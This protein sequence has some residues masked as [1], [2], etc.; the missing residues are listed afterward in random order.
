[1]NKFLYV[2]GA[3][4][5]FTSCSVNSSNSTNFSIELGNEFPIKLGEKFTFEESTIGIE[6]QDVDDYRCNAIDIMCVWAG[7]ATIDLIFDGEQIQL[8]LYNRDQ[9]FVIHN[10]YKIEFIKLTP[11]L[12]KGV[13]PKDKYKAFL[14][15]SAL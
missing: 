3:F 12:R 9:P 11:E 14:K 8:L 1:M 13:L 4:L 2:I 5:L 7:N 6:L 15:V 10:G